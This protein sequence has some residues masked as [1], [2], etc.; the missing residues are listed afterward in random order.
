MDRQNALFSEVEGR[1][2]Q[3]EPCGFRYREEIVTKEEEASLVTSLGQLDLKP[4]EVA[5]GE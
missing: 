3:P 2:T 1:S 4:F 5:A